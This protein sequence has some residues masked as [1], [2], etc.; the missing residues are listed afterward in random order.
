[1]GRD[2]AMLEI[3]GL[4]VLVRTA[5]LLEQTVGRVA[6]VGP[7]ERYGILGLECVEPEDVSAL[8]G[9]IRYVGH[10]VTALRASET[11]WNLIVG[12][13]MPYLRRSWVKYLIRRALRSDAELVV[14]DCLCAMLRKE[15]EARIRRAL[16]Q[17][18][19]K[20]WHA[21]RYLARDAVEDG[22]MERFRPD[23]LLP[24][25]L[26]TTEAYEVARSH[27]EGDP[28]RLAEYLSADA[29]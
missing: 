1:M 23:G 8:H 11:D 14:G 27:I 9:S 21:M 29:V 3:G 10:L 2:K 24:F 15:A 16:D 20:F 18:E 6:V 4:P 5:R 22:V 13:D 25:D 19:L 7:K 26:D 28:M 17:G 12:C